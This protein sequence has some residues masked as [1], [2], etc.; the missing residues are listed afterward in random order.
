MENKIVNKIYNGHNISFLSFVT[1]CF[2]VFGACHQS[3]QIHFIYLENLYD[4]PLTLT[5]K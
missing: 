4:C 5:I 2:L 1:V 3:C